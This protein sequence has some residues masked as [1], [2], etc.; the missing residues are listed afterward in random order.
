[1]S[2]LLINKTTL[3]SRVLAQMTAEKPVMESRKGLM[4]IAAI[5]RSINIGPS[6]MSSLKRRLESSLVRSSKKESKFSKQLRI[7]K[8]DKH[9]LIQN[10]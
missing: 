9:S 6:Q 2:I 8:E 10:F 1:M 4:G 7:H 3:K 5:I